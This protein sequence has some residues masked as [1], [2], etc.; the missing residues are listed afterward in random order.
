MMFHDGERTVDFVLVWWKHSTKTSLQNG[1]QNNS[2]RE[3]ERKREIFE[4]HLVN[5]GLELERESSS[6]KLNFVKIHAPHEVLSRYCEI[7]KMRMP[8]REV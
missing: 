1:A 5:E 3:A 8:M 4:K 7:M 6:D 2:I